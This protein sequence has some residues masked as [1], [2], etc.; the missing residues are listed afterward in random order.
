MEIGYYC[1][2]ADNLTGEIPQGA[3]IQQSG[4]A[5]TIQ[6]AESEK[7]AVR[8]MQH[9][10]RSCYELSDDELKGIVD[11]MNGV[12]TIM[13]ESGHIVNHFWNFRSHRV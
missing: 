9:S 8:M 3:I 2:T 12:V 5:I 1:I 10:I 7:E 11:E 13:D 4:I 6:I